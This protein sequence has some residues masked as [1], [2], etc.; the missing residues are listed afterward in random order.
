M[1]CGECTI[2]N[3]V[4][5]RGGMPVQLRT[6][7]KYKIIMCLFHDWRF[8]S[9]KHG[10]AKPCG[11][12]VPIFA[13]RVDVTTITFHCAKCGAIKQKTLRGYWTEEEVIGRK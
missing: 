5:V 11:L 4:R 12:F 8:S 10:T 2:P 3:T 6:V 1:G 7:G 13:D 9:V